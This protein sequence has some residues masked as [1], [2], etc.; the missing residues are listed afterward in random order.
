MILT[1]ETEVLGEILSYIYFV[2][3]TS[4]HAALLS[5][6]FLCCNPALPAVS[7]L[8]LGASFMLCFVQYMFGQEC[9]SIRKTRDFSLPQLASPSEHLPLEVEFFSINL[10]TTQLPNRP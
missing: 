5:Y 2:F 7:L 10:L 3:T 8:S 6:P 9:Q 4:T 1:G